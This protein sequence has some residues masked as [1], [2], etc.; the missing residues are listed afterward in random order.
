MI[1]E[2]IRQGVYVKDIAAELGVH[3]RAWVSVPTQAPITP[4]LGY[5]AREGEV[6]AEDAHAI[7]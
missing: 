5:L 7:E 2:R 3:P 4:T 1:Q 6:E